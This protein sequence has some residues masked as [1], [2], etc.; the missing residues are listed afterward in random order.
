[1]LSCSPALCRTVNCRF[2]G[3][4]IYPGRGI[5]FIRSDGAVSCCLVDL[6]TCVRPALSSGRVA[7]DS[8][9]SSRP[10]LLPNG[11]SCTAQTYLFLNQ[12]AKSMF[13]QRKRPAKLAWTAQFRKAH[14]K[15]TPANGNVSKMCRGLMT[16][17]RPAET[18]ARQC[19]WGDSSS[20]SW[21][22]C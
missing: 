13:H 19:L 4:R 15:V 18:A 3:L 9:R 21:Q 17:F 5:Q 7:M 11:V 22:R 12:K 20:G 2:S 6:C 1:M 16:M 10:V 8:P 14:K